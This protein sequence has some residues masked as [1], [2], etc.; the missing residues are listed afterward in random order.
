[1]QK[2][3]QRYGITLTIQQLNYNPDQTIK[4]FKGRFETD[5]LFCSTQMNEHEFDIQG[6]FK[7]MQFT[8]RVAN[9]KEL[10]YLKI[11]SDDFEQT[12]ECYDDKVLTSSMQAERAAR[13][14]ERQLFF[15]QREA[16]NA[17]RLMHLAQEGAAR[18]RANILRLKADSIHFM[19]QQQFEANF[20]AQVLRQHPMLSDSVYN[21][22]IYFDKLNTELE[23]LERITNSD[24][25]K[26]DSL[27]LRNS[28]QDQSS[29]LRFQIE[30]IRLDIEKDLQK[31]LQKEQGR[32]RG[33][34]REIEMLLER[35]G[36]E[37]LEE[38]S[39]LELELEAATMEAEA[40]RLKKAAKALK[41]AAKQK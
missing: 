26:M 36:K 21:L 16:E 32:E 7:S 4:R 39:A 18:S 6:S 13:L 17:Q 12:I 24:W 14:A 23:V 9:E 22:E 8:F 31:R 3:L 28:L 10:K 20:P 30:N 2:E 25:F 1:M 19:T 27:L 33:L 34:E 5:S 15:A 37:K 35:K 41:K 40:K 38:R 29:E 11:Q